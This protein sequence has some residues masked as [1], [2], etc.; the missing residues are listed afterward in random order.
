M[1]KISLTQQQLLIG[2]SACSGALGASI[3]ATVIAGAGI[4][5]APL[6]MG[7]SLVVAAGVATLWSAAT[8]YGTGFR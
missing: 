4:F 3:G 7:T 1:K 5:F 2:G 8:C 6:S